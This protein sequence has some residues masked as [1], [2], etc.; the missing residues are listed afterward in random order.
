MRGNYILHHLS[1]L[2]DVVLS[3][4]TK[5]RLKQKPHKDEH[6]VYW[7][8]LVMNR[9]P[10]LQEFDQPNLEKLLKDAKAI[11]HGMLL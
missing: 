10:Y 1:D 7:F 4:G 5:F 6:G 2:G 3:D 9:Q 11:I 8:S